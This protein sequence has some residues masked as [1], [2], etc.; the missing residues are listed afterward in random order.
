MTNSNHY[1]ILVNMTHDQNITVEDLVNEPDPVPVLRTE[2]RYVVK[3]RYADNLPYDIIYE[4]D[5]SERASIVFVDEAKRVVQTNPHFR[6]DEDPLYAVTQNIKGR[7]YHSEWCKVKTHDERVGAT[8]QNQ[9]H[10]TPVKGIITTIDPKIV[11]SWRPLRREYKIDNGSG[12]TVRIFRKEV[13]V[14]V[15]PRTGLPVDDENAE[16]ETGDEQPEESVLF[17]GMSRREALDAILGKKG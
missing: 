4:S 16:I 13:E 15:D 17:D 11:P 14:W 6:F 1:S 7:S 3:R 5:D 9:Y 8:Y 12:Y 2:N 10:W